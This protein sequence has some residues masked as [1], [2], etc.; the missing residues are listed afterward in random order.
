MRQPGAKLKCAP[1]LFFLALM[2]TVAEGAVGQQSAAQGAP[3]VRFL[4]TK[5]PEFEIRD[6]TLVDGLWKLAGAPAP[7]AFGFEE[8]LKKS[9]SD[10]DIQDP[11]FSLQLKNKT[12]REVLDALCQKDSRFTW[13][14]DGATVNVFPQAI[15]DDSSY[16]L[17]RKLERFELKN[18]TDVE[19]GLLAI[20]RQLPPPVEQVAHAQIGGA[21]PYPPEPW[22]VTFENLT[23]RQ[24][25][26]RLA[27]HGGPCGTWIFGGATDFRSFGFFNTYACS[28]QLPPWIQKI[29]DSRP[30]STNGFQPTTSYPSWTG[31]VTNGGTPTCHLFLPHFATPLQW[32]RQRPGA[33]LFH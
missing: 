23:V 12:V 28:K 32:Q 14:M 3:E 27:L 30:K 13:S 18:A 29:I 16:L 11:K 25:V 33:N 26:N 24:V 21:D 1:I 19:N 31:K 7:F 10:P 9:L 20:V 5:V 4:D 17:N 22:T 2:F 15:I 8:V 6:Q